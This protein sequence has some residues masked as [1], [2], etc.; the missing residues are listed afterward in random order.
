MPMPD[1]VPPPPDS[2]LFGQPIKAKGDSGREEYPGGKGGYIFWQWTKEKG[3]RPV[4][5]IPSGETVI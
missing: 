2:G 3:W 1:A 4:R 5:Y